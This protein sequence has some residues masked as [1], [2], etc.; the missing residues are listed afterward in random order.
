MSNLFYKLFSR[1]QR[2]LHERAEALL[3]E[4]RKADAAVQFKQLL[5]GGDL[6]V[7][8]RLGQLYERGYGGAAKFRRGGARVQRRRRAGS[9]PAMARLGEIYLTGLARRTPG[10]G[11][12]LLKVAQASGERFTAY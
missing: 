11:P 7:K 3:A 10:P 1:W 6:Q 2:P 8:L 4:G 9:V 5:E 12:R